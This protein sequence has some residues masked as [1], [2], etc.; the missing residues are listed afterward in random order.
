[1]YCFGKYLVLN[2]TVNGI[3]TIA[4][5]IPFARLAG[6]RLADWFPNA[7]MLLEGTKV[8]N[9]LIMYF[10]IG[11]TAWCQKFLAA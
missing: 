1:M 8:L 9:S 4:W 11:K 6:V 3:M 2:F 10:K 7:V 5:R